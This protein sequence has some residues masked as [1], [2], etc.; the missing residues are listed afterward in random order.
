[1]ALRARNR[2]LEFSWKVCAQQHLAAFDRILDGQDP[3][4]TFS[5]FALQ[6]GWYELLDSK[7]FD[8]GREE[9]LSHARIRGDAHRLLPWLSAQESAELAERSWEAG[10]ID[11]ALALAQKAEDRALEARIRDRLQIERLSNTSVEIRYC[12]PSACRAQL[13]V[14]CNQAGR[15]SATHVFGDFAAFEMNPGFQLQL[16]LQETESEPFF[17]LMLSDGTMFWDRPCS[18]SG[19][20]AP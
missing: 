2:A 5:A 7:F 11:G 1:L 20:L 18:V 19:R 6:V 8:N 10:N 16:A 9:L 4:A 13:F 15:R 17:L 3:D 12:H 14:K